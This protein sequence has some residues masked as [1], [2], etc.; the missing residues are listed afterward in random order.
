M[1]EKVMKA[2]DK[3]KV[4]AGWSGMYSDWI[5]LTVE[6]FRFCLGVFQSSEHRVAER[7]TPL[8]ELYCDGPETE[9]EYISHMGELRTNQVPAWIDVPN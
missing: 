2:G 9:I 3:I 5:E 7:F 1:S 4:D 8:C 6:E